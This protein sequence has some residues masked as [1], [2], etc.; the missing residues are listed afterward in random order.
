MRTK[1]IGSK[2]KFLRTLA[3]EH[4]D[5]ARQHE[6][7][8][9]PYDMNANMS[10]MCHEC[11]DLLRDAHTRREDRQV[12]TKHGPVLLAAW[13]EAWHDLPTKQ[14]KYDLVEVVADPKSAGDAGVV[15]AVREVQED[16][17][18]WYTEGATNGD[19]RHQDPAPGQG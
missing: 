6:M 14:I 9:K 2:I 13:I 12:N 4:A 16:I 7:G 5:K 11:A 17:E 1:P 15:E 8:S 19:D 10:A 18:D 3:Q